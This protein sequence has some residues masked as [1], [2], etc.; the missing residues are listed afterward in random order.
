MPVIFVTVEEALGD[1]AKLKRGERARHPAHD[2]GKELRGELVSAPPG[3]D[4]R[5]SWRS[6]PGGH[7][8]RAARGC[9]GIRH[10]GSGGAQ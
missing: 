5:C 2:L 9:R 3:P 1:L 6:G 10:R 7:P 4:P 8:I